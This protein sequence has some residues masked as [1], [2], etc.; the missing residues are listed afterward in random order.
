MDSPVFT[1]LLVTFA[2]AAGVVGWLR[3]R[4]IES[5]SGTFWGW[6]G[7]TTQHRREHQKR[8]S[9]QAPDRCTNFLLTEALTN[10]AWPLQESVMGLLLPSAI[11]RS[12]G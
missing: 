2:A 7:S 4:S 9:A 3:L 8:A 5:Q 6:A 11:R 1:S 12:S 10:G